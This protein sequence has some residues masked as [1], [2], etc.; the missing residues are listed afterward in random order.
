[1]PPLLPPAT[2]DT[3]PASTS[4]SQTDTRTQQ[5]PPADPK[6]IPGSALPPTSSTPQLR[7]SSD[8][9]NPLLKAWI[10]RLY[11]GIKSLPSGLVGIIGLL[12][13]VYAAIS[14][15]VEI[16][17]AFNQIYNAPEG[18][19]WIRRITQYWTLL[20][21][22]TLFLIMSFY[23]QDR[24]SGVARDLSH[25]V[26]TTR[27][28]RWFIFHSIGFIATV[29]ISTLLLLIVFMIVPNTRVQFMPALIGAV[30]SAILWESGKWGFAR[31]VAYSNAPG[32]GYTRFYGAVAILPLFML[33]IYFTWMIVLMGLQLASALQTNRVTNAEGFHFSVL[34][35]FGL[36]DEERQKRRVK[37]VDP[38]SVILVLIAVAERFAIGKSSDHADVASKTGIDEQAVAD[39]LDRLAGAGML[40]RVADGEH[41]GTYT[42]A[43]PPDAIS[44]VPVLALAQELVGSS[45]ADGSLV[46]ANLARV[47]NEALA[48]KTIADLMEKAP[49]PTA[50]DFK[51]RARSGLSARPLSATSPCQHTEE[52]LDV[53]VGADVSIPIKVRRITRGAARSRDAGEERIDIHIRAHIAVVIEVRAAAGGGRRPLDRE[54]EAGRVPRM[55]QAIEDRAQHALWPTPIRGR[56]CTGTRYWASPG[57]PHTR[58]SAQRKWAATANRCPAPST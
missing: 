49:A 45:R 44:A 19:S 58:R 4:P 3:T 7:P 56:G 26:T 48:G 34:A 22:G 53:R 39:M 2:A 11:S 28:F 12:T 30:T 33:W 40:L 51:A 23:V 1:M 50:L 31:Y 16:E 29:G 17:K 14:M 36:I 10:D 37:I 38:V 32:T 42:L 43:R 24:I 20:T 15:L 52:R 5:G 9:R 46:M 25:S 57:P 47:R 54:V 21:L 55:V 13:L 27:E 8:D 35:T 41:E 6:A 18:R